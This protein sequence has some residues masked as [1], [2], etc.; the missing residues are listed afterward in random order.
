MRFLLLVSIFGLFI[1]NLNASS[2]VKKQWLEN[3][4]RSYA[5][6][7]YIW[8]YLKQDI[9]ASEAIWALGQAR[10][11]NNKLLRRYANKLK[12]QDTNKVLKCMRLKALSFVKRDA[13]C[14]EVGLTS[15]KATKLKKNQLNKIIQ[16]VKEPFPNSA[17]RFE[18]INSNTPFKLLVKSSTKVFYETFNETGGVFRVN[19]FNHPLPKSYIKELRKEKKHFEQ[20]IRL[21]VTNPKLTKIQESLLT[22]NPNGL[23]HKSQFFLSINAIQHKKKKLALNYLKHSFKSAYFKFDQDKVRFW[24]YKLTNKKVYLD[25][26]ANSWDI[27]MYSMIA[28]EQK[29]IIPKNIKYASIPNKQTIT[30]ESYDV[31]DPF[32]WIRVLRNIKKLDDTKVE[33]YK[34][35]FTTKETQGHLSFI[36]ERYER[37]RNS[38]FALPYQDL[39]KDYTIHRQALINAI[40][41]Q[42]SRFIPTSI[43][44]A[45]ALGVMQIMP[46]LSKALAKELKEPYDIDK[47]LTPSTNLRYAN[48]HLNYLERKLSNVLFVAYA[49]NGGIGFTKRILRTGLFKKREYEPYLSMELVPYDESKRYAKKVILNYMVYF[50]HLSKKEK[51]S[52]LTLMEKIKSPHQK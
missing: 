19:N 6:D 22:L 27:N 43:S 45:Y 9:N 11:V 33:N 8:R 31:T 35:I 41:R 51:T 47:Q 36:L 18:I 39:L 32:S 50:N 37:Y 30:T 48:K 2:E 25:E 24:Q 4:P 10:Y 26:L 46:F 20:T 14:I 40:A 17:R 34:N 49:Y 28:K 23:S 13:E 15:F 29:N 42:E 44:T 5:K 52:M 1:L 16:T 7:F 38:Y 3:K 21:I 12:H